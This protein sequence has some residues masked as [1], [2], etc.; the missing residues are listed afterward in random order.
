MRA[1]RRA[2]PRRRSSRTPVRPRRGSMSI[3]TSIDTRRARADASSTRGTQLTVDDDLYLRPTRDQRRSRDRPSGAWSTGD[4]IRIGPIPARASTIASDTF[5]AQMP[6]A[7]A[8]NCRC[9]TCGHLC[10]FACGRKPLPRAPRKSAIRAMLRF[11]ASSSS[12]SAGVGTS[13]SG[14]GASNT[15]GVSGRLAR[16][17]SESSIMARRSYERRAIGTTSRVA[18]STKNRR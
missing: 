10:V 3:S 11:S 4:V 1:S 5:A 12:N 2:S 17:R 7:P 18:S 15:T 8:A 6:T 13:A 16:S 9:A 14:I